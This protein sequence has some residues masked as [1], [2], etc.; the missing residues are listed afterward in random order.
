M[1][2]ANQNTFVKRLPIATVLPFGVLSLEPAVEY[3]ASTSPR[4]RLVRTTPTP[5]L[6]PTPRPPCV[7]R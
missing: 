2:N 7:P 5:P 4:A 3:T 6:V 1:R